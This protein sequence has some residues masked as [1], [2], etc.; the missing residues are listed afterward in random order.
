MMKV[1]E[2][3]NGRLATASRKG[4]VEN[5]TAHIADPFNSTLFEY[6]GS[7][8]MFAASGRKA[9]EWSEYYGPNRRLWLGPNTR[10]VPDRVEVTPCWP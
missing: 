1:R 4:P 7:L 9:A 6:T 8:A 5:W 10:N 2:I 3:K